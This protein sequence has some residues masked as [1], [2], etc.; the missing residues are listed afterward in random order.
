MGDPKD[1]RDQLMEKVNEVKEHFKEALAELKNL[2]DL[3][4][5]RARFI[6][7][8]GE[9]SELM[10]SLKTLP[11]EIVRELGRS[12]NQLKEEISKHL[13]ELEKKLGEEI[14]RKRLLEE[15]KDLSVR[16]KP[17]Y[18]PSIHPLTRI[19]RELKEVFMGLGFEV[20]EGPELEEEYYNFDGLNIPSDHPARDM[21]DSF[22]VRP[23]YLLR[24]HTSPVQVR[25][26]TTRKPPFKVVSL[27]KCY[28]RDDLDPTHSFQF[29]QIEG[30]IVDK[31]ITFA[32]LKGVLMEFASRVFGGK[33]KV[34]LIPSYFPFTEPSAEV[35]IDCFRC[36]GKDPHCPICKG[37]G[38]IEVLG[39]GMIHPNVL[40]NAGI[41]PQ[42]WTG[43]AFGMGIERIAML[44]YQIDD[45]R[46]F[47]ENRLDFLKQFSA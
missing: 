29:H 17:T 25:V 38:W 22:W 34:K 7:P 18:T 11:K 43:F 47:Y 36:G 28:R 1:L 41:S 23:G 13:S 35:A 42:E 14:L 45:I 44:K 31:G 39:A 46:L 15:R 40:S 30:F 2:E 32:H 12:L 9:V 33:R 8:K 21:W 6:G 5:I 10:K 20:V 19:M 4:R 26:M 27:G 37:E 3:K 16:Y 24:S